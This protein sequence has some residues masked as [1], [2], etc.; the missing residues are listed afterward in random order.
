MKRTHLVIMAPSR[1]AVR[2]ARAL[3]KTGV[4]PSV[5]LA[6]P[7]R[8]ERGCATS[9]C[10]VRIM[11][12]VMVVLPTMVRFAVL[13][14]APRSSAG[15]RGALSIVVALGVVAFLGVAHAVVAVLVRRAAC[16]VRVP[17][18][19]A[20]RVT[21]A[22]LA[23]SCLGA[24][25][26]AP[27]CRLAI[28]LRL[29]PADIAELVGRAAGVVRVAVHAHSHVALAARAIL[30]VIWARRP[31]AALCDA[32]VVSHC[33]VTNGLAATLCCT[34]AVLVAFDTQSTDAL[35]ALAHSVS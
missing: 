27:A 28:D 32:L 9:T 22:A 13:V 1:V 20:H 2:A 19:H 14:R 8:A 29:A 23:L 15:P 30:V 18:L 6:F 10:A 34:L 25:L 33:R 31:V 7:I 4:P 16:V 3:F 5:G 24:R 12:T 11:L 35:V 21:L 17:A 26:S